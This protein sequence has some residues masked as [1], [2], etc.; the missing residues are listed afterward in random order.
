MKQ[1][2]FNNLILNAFDEE[3]VK[4]RIGNEFEMYEKEMEMAKRFSQM[5]FEE[6][7]EIH[8]ESLYEVVK[9][10]HGTF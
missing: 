7:A 5:T 3:F 9:K 6:W 10:Y 4:T 8:A 1:Q 2:D